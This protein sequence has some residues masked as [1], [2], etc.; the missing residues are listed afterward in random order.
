MRVALGGILAWFGAHQVANTGDWVQFVPGFISGSSPVADDVLIVW[1]GS[2]LLIASFGVLLGV[3]LRGAA[4][5]AAI[6]LIGIMTALVVKGDSAHLI[7]RDLGLLGLA[8]AVACDPVRFVAL[9]FRLRRE[10]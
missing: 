7:V 9:G 2:A 1:H 3:A 8:I 5:L 10:K 6:L 4:V